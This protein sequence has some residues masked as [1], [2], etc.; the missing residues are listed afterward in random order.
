[1]HRQ[2]VRAK[3]EGLFFNVRSRIYLARTCLNVIGIITGIDFEFVQDYLRR[4]EI[5]TT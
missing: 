1:M 4:P 3:A 2:A 5:F